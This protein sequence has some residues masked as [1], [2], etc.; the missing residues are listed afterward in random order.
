M[1]KQVGLL[2]LDG[3]RLDECLSGRGHEEVLRDE[4]DAE[5]IGV[6][7]TPTFMIGFLLPEKRL[8]VVTTIS[9]AQPVARFVHAL[10]GLLAQ[11]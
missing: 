3:P 10:D 6:K 2:K 11:K 5:A 1:N 8:Q 9:G 4:A 7:S